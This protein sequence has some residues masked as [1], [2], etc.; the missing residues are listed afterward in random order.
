MKRYPINSCALYKVPSRRVL[1]RF[2]Q[3]SEQKLQALARE[4]PY[5]DWEKP[6]K[7]GGVRKI[8][9]P[10]SDLKRVQKRVATLLGRVA[11]PDFLSAPVKGRSYV[12]NAVRHRGGRCIHT[13]DISNF[14][15]NCTAKRVAW[16][17]G[18]V[19]HCPPD[20]NG[21]LVSL[22]TRDGRLP[23]GSPSS[24]ILAYFAYMDMWNEI[25]RMVRAEGCILSVYV[26]DLAV[27][28]AHVP[29]DLIWRIR[30]SIHRHGH[31][32]HPEKERRT[33]DGPIE[34]TGVILRDG[35][36]FLPNRQ[37]KKLTELR[38]T[39][40]SRGAGED[41]KQ[42]ERQLRGREAQARQVLS[43]TGWSTS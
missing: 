39:L 20:V 9:A 30:Q 38:R 4:Q 37:H 2:L 15:P 42:A 11:P 5:E 12:D 3:A 18:T 14:Y 32:S 23:Q 29:G 1:A 27:S 13:L 41:R 19:L 26:D 24:P 40:A 43:R 22:T 7:S 35:Q 16:F 34:I 31:K 8:E 21:I 25:D 36:V 33:M 28:G 10:R 6:K 17:F